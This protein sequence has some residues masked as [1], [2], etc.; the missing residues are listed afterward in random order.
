MK[1]SLIVA[2][3]SNRVIGMDNHMPWHLSADLKKFKQITM[4]FPIILGRK[5]FEAIGKPLPGR[6]NIIISR[7]LGYQYDGCRVFASLEAA[8]S[9]ACGESPQVFVIGGATLYEAVLPIA[10]ELYLTKIEQEFVGDTF[11]PELDA[12]KWREVAR[13]DIA[14]DPQVN[15]RYSFLRLVKVTE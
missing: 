8:L 11:F 1:I 3:S 14:D 15:F 9:Y 12:T 10:D 5:T 13:E 2:M 6:T 7:N 4:G